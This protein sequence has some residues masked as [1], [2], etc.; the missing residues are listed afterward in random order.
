MNENETRQLIDRSIILGILKSIKVDGENR[1]ISTMMPRRL[2]TYVT[3]EE[4][5]EKVPLNVR[6]ILSEWMHRVYYYDRYTS[7]AEKMKKGEP[8]Q[9]LPNEDILLLD[10]VLEMIDAA[11]DFAVI[12]CNCRALDQHCDYEVETC[13]R[14]DHEA[15]D[16]EK[17]GLGKNLTKEEARNLVISLNKAGHIHT[18]SNK[19]KDEGLGH[20]CNCCTCCCYPF[21][22]GVELGLEK[23]WPKSHYIAGYNEDVCIQCGVCISR[24]Q[25]GAYTKKDERIEYDPE[26]CWG[27]GLCANTCPT[28]AITIN[29][30]N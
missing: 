14:F 16:L 24:C 2:F 28:K 20:L 7:M 8:V 12:K 25:F 13:I 10:E 6:K 23:M 17:K 9:R 22:A 4:G 11:H 26:K 27:C 18:G 30:L 5:W 1:Y 15:M 21:R 29:A 19:W 3:F